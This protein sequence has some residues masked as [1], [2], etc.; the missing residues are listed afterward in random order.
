MAST[1]LGSG[2][3]EADL[4]SRIFKGDVNE[5]ELVDNLVNGEG[6]QVSQQQ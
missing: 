2:D 1:A 6:F 5:M 4:I 3:P